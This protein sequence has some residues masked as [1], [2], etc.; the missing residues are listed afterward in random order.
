M[1]S[2]IESRLAELGIELPEPQLPT[3]AK[4][5]P[6][7]IVE[8]TLYV[9]GQVTTWNGDLRY[10]GKVGREFDLEEGRA[11]A[12]LSALNVLAQAKLALDG[13]LDRVARVVNLR[14]FVNAMPDFTDIPAVVNGASELMIDLFGD[15]GRHTRT[16]VGVAVMPFDVAIEVE[17]IFSID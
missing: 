13:D 6:A 14:G 4:I 17:A 10:I 11:A 16:A 1:T 12:R 7:M 15:A 3:V 2:A 9:S 5:L 8:R